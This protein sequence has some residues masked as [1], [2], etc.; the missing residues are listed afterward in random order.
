[1]ARK[2]R[3]FIRYKSY[4]FS[5]RDPILEVV[6]AARS[7]QRMK[8]KTIHDNGGPTPATLRN[9]ESGKTRR[10]QFCTIAAASRT[11]GKKGIMFGPKGVP[12]LVD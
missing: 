9:W 1:M 6:T 7:L 2:K 3:G 11:L 4:L 12:Y 10:P 5:E 8:Y